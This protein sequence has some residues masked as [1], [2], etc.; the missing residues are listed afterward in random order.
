MSLVLQP[1]LLQDFSERRS[2]VLA[3]W[4]LAPAKHELVVIPDCAADGRTRDHPLVAAAPGVRF[5]AATPIVTA[6]GQRLG[7]V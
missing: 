1:L 7:A 4:A 2:N 5:L 6:G 3:A